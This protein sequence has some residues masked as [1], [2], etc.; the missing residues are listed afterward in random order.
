MPYRIY[1]NSCD[2]MYDIVLE[3]DEELDTIPD[4]QLVCSGCGDLDVYKGPYKTSEE[5]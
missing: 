3:D 1:C 4:E 2:Y 5:D